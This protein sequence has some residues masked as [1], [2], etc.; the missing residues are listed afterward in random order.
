MSLPYTTNEILASEY[1]QDLGMNKYFDNM[2]ENDTVIY[3]KITTLTD[4][5]KTSKQ[6]LRE[7]RI[8]N[9]GEVQNTKTLQKG[10]TP[11][12]LYSLSATDTDIYTETGGLRVGRGQGVAN[13]LMTAGSY[14]KLMGKI[15]SRTRFID[16][17][18]FFTTSDPV[19]TDSGHRNRKSFNFREGSASFE[20]GPNSDQVLQKAITVTP[21]I[22]GL[23]DNTL[24]YVRYAYQ[25]KI[26]SYTEG[27]SKKDKQQARFE[28]YSLRQNTY[29]MVSS[30][31]TPQSTDDVYNRIT[32]IRS[33]FCSKIQIKGNANSNYRTRE[34]IGVHTDY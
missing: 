32:F 19:F 17:S 2:L 21:E 27:W 18:M 1:N 29:K 22:S 12:N 30:D 16:L 25:T 3:D 26:Y 7:L 10:I 34:G 11:N 4:P 20:G 14:G 13:R 33:R 24:I 28:L 9:V 31:I 6:K 23:A 5:T 8:S 15:A